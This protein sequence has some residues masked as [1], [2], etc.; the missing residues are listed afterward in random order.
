MVCWHWFGDWVGQDG[1]SGWDHREFSPSDSW[2][3]R[4]CDRM[5]SMSFEGTPLMTS[6]P[7][8]Y[9]TSSRF[10]RLL[11]APQTEDH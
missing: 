9:L 3:V 11:K 6:L 1:I 10:H 8:L 2:E 4:K 5:A 7:P